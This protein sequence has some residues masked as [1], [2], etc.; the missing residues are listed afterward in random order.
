MLNVLLE[1]RKELEEVK[2]SKKAAYDWRY[3]NS[4]HNGKQLL[5]LSGNLEHKYAQWRTNSSLSNFADTISQ[6]NDMNLNYHISDKLHY[7]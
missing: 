7:D 3:E 1:E 5:D 6:C 4:I 2:V